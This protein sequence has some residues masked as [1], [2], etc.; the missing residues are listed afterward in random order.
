MTEER[1]EQ[2]GEKRCNHYRLQPFSAGMLVLGDKSRLPGEL[3][4]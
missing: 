4:D 1:E 2:R 3:F